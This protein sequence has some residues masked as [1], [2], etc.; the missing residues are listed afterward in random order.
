VRRS[1]VLVGAQLCAALLIL[2]SCSVSPYPTAEFH[3]FLG[4]RADNDY[5]TLPSGERL[6][7]ALVNLGVEGTDF[8]PRVVV[9]WFHMVD[10][11]ES[12]YPLDAA[13]VEEDLRKMGELLIEFADQAGW[14]ND[15]HLYVCVGDPSSWSFSYDYETETLYPP[16]EHADM[17][18]I[19]R[20]FDTRNF[21]S[22]A[23]DDKG[24]SYLLARG[25]AETRHGKVEPTLKWSM[26]FDPEKQFYVTSDGEFSE[27][28]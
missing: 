19:T 26:A 8:R 5:I 13:T 11:F 25:Y 27:I 10:P 28:G 14:P 2:G 23:R 22:I 20:R 18:E 4:S 17:R 21:Q 1:A 9:R 3:D 6:L 24:K 7:T 15:Y 12:T 16:R